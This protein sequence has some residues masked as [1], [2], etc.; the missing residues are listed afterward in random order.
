MQAIKK[1]ARLFE[2]VRQDDKQD[3]KE[4]E[5]PSKRART[6]KNM[7]SGD[8]DLEFADA[9]HTEEQVEQ[10]E[11][12][13][14]GTLVSTLQDKYKGEAKIENVVCVA[15]IADHIPLALLGSRLPS[16]EYRPDRF[17]ADKTRLPGI[18]ILIYRTG[19]ILVPGTSD[20]S[21]ST[22]VSHSIVLMMSNIERNVF[23]YDKETKKISSVKRVPLST[24]LRFQGIQTANIVAKTIYDSKWIRLMDMFILNASQCTYTPSTFSA[25]RADYGEFALLLFKGNFLILGSTSLNDLKYSNERVKSIIMNVY[26]HGLTYDVIKHTVFR[27][28]HAVYNQGTRD[29]EIPALECHLFNKYKL[30]IRSL[31]LWKKRLFLSLGPSIRLDQTK[32]SS[33][34]LAHLSRHHKA[35]L[36]ND[37]Y[38]NRRNSKKS[39]HENFRQRVEDYHNARDHLYKDYEQ[40]YSGMTMKRMRRMDR[41]AFLQLKQSNHIFARN[42]ALF[43]CISLDGSGIC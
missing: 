28:E 7:Y 15:T 40:Y 38:E 18:T 24:S 20:E 9:I 8:M 33:E 43:Q 2:Q 25:V 42:R 32:V 14:Q 3:H 6:I 10:Q 36:H 23:T 41:A 13:Q 35:M 29:D 34:P 5:R 1:L 37:E 27:A 11:Q 22:Y 4:L 39:Q 19:K 16:S 17:A 31:P 30:D 26:Y 21:Q 12:Q